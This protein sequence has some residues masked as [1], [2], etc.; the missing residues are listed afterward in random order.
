[1][2]LSISTKNSTLL[3]INKPY[4]CYAME[5]DNNFISYLGSKKIDAGKFKGA[6]PEL[7]QKLEGV[8]AQTHPD[9]F[10]A[11]KLFLINPIRR[12]YLLEDQEEIV[13]SKPKMKFKP[14]LK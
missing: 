10:T 5:N 11:Q 12:K 7:Y 13:P 14:K 2:H 6:E 8:F 9:S 4:I 1:M 3:F